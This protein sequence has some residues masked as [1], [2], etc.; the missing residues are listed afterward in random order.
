[1]NCVRSMRYLPLILAV[2]FPGQGQSA[3]WDS[4]T[5]NREDPYTIKKINVDVLTAPLSGNSRSWRIEVPE[6]KELA[7]TLDNVVLP[8]GSWLEVS[9]AAGKQQSIYNDKAFYDGSKPQIIT[10]PIDGGVMIIKLFTT[11]NRSSSGHL[12]INQYRYIKGSTRAVIGDNQM[13]QAACYQ[14]INPLFYSKS[15]AVVKANNGSG[16]NVAGGPYVITNH[17]VAGDAGSKSHSLTYNYES[18]GC[19]RTDATNTLQIRTERVV[20]AGSGD[21]D[22]WAVYKVDPLAYE[23]AGIKQIFGTLAI[24]ADTPK[25]ELIKN[26]PLYIAQHPWGDYKRISSLDD[27]GGACKTISGNASETLAYTCDTAG[28]SSGSP[29]LL[30]S[31]SRVVAL[32]YA[33]TSS[34]NIGVIG[35]YL[36]NK[37][38]TLLPDANQASAATLGEGKV[39]VKNL[40]FYP[41]MPV[42]PQDI[43]ATGAISLLSLYEGRLTDDET[44]TLFKAKVRVAGGGIVDANIRFSI[45]TPCGE[46][47]FSDAN[48]CSQ[49]GKRY[50]NSWL[51]R[52][53]NP[54]VG[55]FTGWVAIRIND[56]KDQRLHNLILPVSYS[57]YDPFSSPFAEDSKVTEYTLTEKSTLTTSQ[58]TYKS[59]L[60][61]VAVYAGQ[62]PLETV[63][64][65]TGYTT[66]KVQV[67]NA[68]GQVYIMTLR[69][70]RKTT[71]SPALRPINSITGCGNV[72]P[73][74]LVLSY[75]KED[76]MTLPVD[77]YSGILPIMAKRDSY[78]IAP[79]LIH[80]EVAKK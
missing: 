46:K 15:H 2:F 28:G 55:S 73:A 59:N 38:K 3:S 4:S 44:S 53:D 14:D 71:C 19:S 13:K 41:D 78:D 43:E 23:E 79:I 22:D 21:T 17:H 50:L 65:G 26:L 68:A 66:L 54:G 33:G 35:P 51:L 63:T 39:L 56:D 1:M 10:S 47:N 64:G 31:D 12:V 6:V 9:D 45:T 74:A 42:P 70:N 69:G 77:T 7:A 32:H 27:D 58:V 37:V 52:T 76:N 30:Q 8:T 34:K 20:I 24:N 80:I 16:W 29:V 5:V 40:D 60:G 57:S 62:G 61:F 18:P 49:A 67:K 72:K 25:N 11:G 75:N 48:Q 36:Y